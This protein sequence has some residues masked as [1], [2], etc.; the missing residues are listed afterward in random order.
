MISTPAELA[1]WLEQY[2][3]D[4][5]STYTVSLAGNL[6]LAPRRQE[7]VG[8]AQGAP[9]LAAGEMLFEAEELEYVSNQ[10]TGYCPRATSFPAVLH[11]LKTAGLRTDKA[12]FDARFEFRRCEGCGERAILKDGF[13]DCVSCGAELPD[14]WNFHRDEDPRS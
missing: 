12:D 2:S 14:R 6:L 13:T 4:G 7:H 8:C 9:V 5:W 1:A 10:S 11:A 3:D